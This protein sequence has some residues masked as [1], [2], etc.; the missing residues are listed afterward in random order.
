MSLVIFPVHLFSP[1]EVTSRPLGTVISGGVSLSGEDTTIA[2]DGGGR[3]EVNISGI[4]LRTPLQIKAWRAWD[5]YLARGLQDCAVPLLSLPYANRSSM[6]RG[7]MPTSKLVAN[8]PI[9]PTE[10]QYSRAPI[11]AHLAADAL[12]RATVV[13]ITVDQG[14][15]LVGGECF[16]VGNRAYDIIRPLGGDQFSIWPPLRE[17][18]GQNA[19]CDFSWPRLK[20]RSAQGESWAPTLEYGRRS[21]VS[22]RFLENAA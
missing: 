17:T 11:Y 1:R 2:T 20:C 5:G 16:S 8:D 3:R 18:I 21:E 15:P 22:I 7:M 4:S 19:P 13:K 10:V 9:F 12:L 6:G 14:A